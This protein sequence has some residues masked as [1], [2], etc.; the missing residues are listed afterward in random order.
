MQNSTMEN[1]EI[2]IMKCNQDMFKYK[3]IG[4]DHHSPYMRY[5]M[6]KPAMFAVH[7]FV[8][9]LVTCLHI[10]YISGSS[11]LHVRLRLFDRCSHCSCMFLQFR[12]AFPACVRN[13]EIY[14]FTLS[15][16]MKILKNIEHLQDPGQTDVTK[17]LNMNDK[18]KNEYGNQHAC[19]KTFQSMPPDV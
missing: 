5:K 11:C 12:C 3:K 4:N 6:Q 2:G 17:I 1:A 8:A 14:N 10:C 19:S 13:R 18:Y 16:R 15:K 9:C 7:L